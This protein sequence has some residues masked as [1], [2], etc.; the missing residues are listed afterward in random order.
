MA[1]R[2]FPGTSPGNP[3][4]EPRRAIRIYFVGA[5][6]TGKTTLARYVRDRYGLTL[7]SEVARTLLAELDQVAHRRLGRVAVGRD[8]LDHL[9][10]TGRL[11]VRESLFP[12]GADDDFSR[13]QARLD[14]VGL[15]VA[16]GGDRKQCHE[17]QS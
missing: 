3:H 13:L 2:P 10:G 9:A 15:G 8:V 5:H 1:S 6:A 16:G 4:P 12:V 7:I 11:R 17:G 14:G